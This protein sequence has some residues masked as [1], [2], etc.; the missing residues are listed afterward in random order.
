MRT[1]SEMLSRAAIIFVALT[2]MTGTA[3]MSATLPVNSRFERSVASARYVIAATNAELYR[4]EPY[5]STNLDGEQRLNTDAASASGTSPATIA[6][7]IDLVR[8]QN[9]L[10]A[11]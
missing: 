7:A 2:I 3:V 11:K 10:R 5:V 4:L 8:Y 1:N 6:L 9:A